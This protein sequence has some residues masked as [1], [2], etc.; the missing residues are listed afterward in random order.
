M[1]PWDKRRKQSEIVARNGISHG[2]MGAD[3]VL[4]SKGEMVN[5]SIKIKQQS[6]CMM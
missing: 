5:G 3:N 4:C 1:D 2:G 6:K